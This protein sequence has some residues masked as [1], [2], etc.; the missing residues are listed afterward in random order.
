MRLTILTLGSRGDVQPYIALGLGLKAAGH[1]VCVATSNCYKKFV[2][3][4]GL[5]FASIAVDI[6]GLLSTEEGQAL[7][8]ES[9]NPIRLMTRMRHVVR[10]AE[11]L[12]EH[13]ILDTLHACQGAD[14]IIIGSLMFNYGDY[15][16]EMVQVPLYLS[17]CGPRTPTRAF[18]QIWFPDRPDWVPLGREVYNKLTYYIAQQMLRRFRKPLLNKYWQKA[19]GKPL[20]SHKAPIQHLPILYCYS[21]IVVPKPSD[22]VE[23]QHV[24][25]YW[26]L[27]RRLDWQPPTKLVD[28]LKSGSPPIC[29]TFGSMNT[30][31]SQ[32][33]A[34]VVLK[35]L[36]LAGLRGVLLSEQ[37]GLC[38]DNM[39]DDLFQV[40]TIP[41]DWLFPQAAAV[42][43][44]GGAGTTAACLRAG[45]PS[46]TVPFFAD[47][48]FWGK[49]LYEL[50]VGS[51]PIPYK[52]LSS[53]T[54]SEAIMG[55]ISVGEQRRRAVALGRRIR[56]E[57][58]VA[59]AVDIICNK[60]QRH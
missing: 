56:S 34:S 50:G 26:F 7:L 52:Q 11:P 49:R 38:S 37:A 22:W 17:S 23:D 58:G 60:G 48:S 2:L 54:L 45:I 5:N 40:G 31:K 33:T 57:D 35:T 4:Y 59:Q 25:G 14:R 10:L 43:H 55:A 27:Q 18:Q 36:R 30:Q 42:V 28:F 32:E 9:T 41:H 1:T 12:G 51:R 19:F 46:I 15:I 21:P 8:H 44:H 24:T 6:L 53:T 3:S 16:G 47:Q 29:V 39:S 20:S 13:I